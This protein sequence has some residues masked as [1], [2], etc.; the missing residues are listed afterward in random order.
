MLVLDCEVYSN[1]FLLMFKDIETGK[2]AAFEMYEQKE[3]DIKRVKE[4]MATA[5]TSSLYLRH[6]PE[7]LRLS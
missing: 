2:Y 7:P 5:T 1:Y 3:L 6:W 4:L